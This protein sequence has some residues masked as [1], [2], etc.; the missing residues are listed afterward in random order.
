M[1]YDEWAAT[2]PTAEYPLRVLVNIDSLPVASVRGKA[3]H[4]TANAK[5]IETNEG[6]RIHAEHMEA[7]GHANMPD[8]DAAMPD[9][10]APYALNTKAVEDAFAVPPAQQKPHTAACF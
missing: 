4:T 9:S 2:D 1:Q 7:D 5:D 10:D 8:Y 6:T 3:G